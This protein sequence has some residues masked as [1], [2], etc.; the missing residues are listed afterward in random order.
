MYKISKMVWASKTATAKITAKITTTAL[1]FFLALFTLT[2]NLKAQETQE[3]Q[4]GQ[5]KEQ[6]AKKGGWFVGF[7]PYLLG[8]SEQKSSSSITNL[9]PVGSTV[10]SGGEFKFTAVLPPDFSTAGE[11]AVQALEATARI[12]ETGSAST[13]GSD[14]NFEGFQFALDDGN[15][16]GVMYPSGSFTHCQN[17]F[18]GLL[19]S[20]PPQA[21]DSVPTA[22]PKAATAKWSGAGLQ[23]GYE[24]PEGDRFS[25]QLHNWKGGDIEVSS[26]MVVYDYFLSKNLYA[27]VGSGTIELKALGK[28]QSQRGSA[29]N[30]G[31]QYSFSPSFKLELGYLL[32]S[33][34]A[35][36]TK[37]IKTTRNVVI[38]RAEVEAQTVYLGFNYIGGAG[39]MGAYSSQ[40]STVQGVCD[41]LSQGIMVVSDPLSREISQVYEVT[42]TQ[43]VTVSNPSSNFIYA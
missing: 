8:L 13:D 9:T 2:T 4:A 38:S 23:F 36:V 42:E 32:L 31:W 37:E 14:T 28:T 21:V 27:G 19:A 5:Q 17:H 16:N 6:Q 30:L 22:S 40:C 11:I 43:E 1:L 29:I 7:T 25:L 3:G 33:A 26:Q 15:W 20:A 12:C 39:A 18:A 34:E 35:S 41:L 24:F 10:D